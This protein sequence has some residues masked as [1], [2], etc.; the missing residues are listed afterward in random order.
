MAH[1]AGHGCPECEKVVLNGGVAAVVLEE[2]CYTIRRYL[3]AG[4]E[5]ENI[6][7]LVLRANKIE[8]LVFEFQ[9]AV[10]EGIGFEGPWPNSLMKKH[11]E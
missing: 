9:R 2:T 4:G 11:S 6:Q 5:F 3:D 7:D 10:L 1:V 8:N